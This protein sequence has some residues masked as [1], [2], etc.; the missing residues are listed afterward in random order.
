M[1]HRNIEIYENG[2]A[3]QSAECMECC[4]RRPRTRAPSGVE[5]GMS[6]ISRVFRKGFPPEKIRLGLFRVVMNVPGVFN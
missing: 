1:F 5:I 4:P 6:R 3:V 2:L